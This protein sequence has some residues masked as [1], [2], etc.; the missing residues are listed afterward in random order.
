M[1]RLAD[2]LRGVSAALADT[3]RREE[4]ILI[5]EWLPDLEDEGNPGT[6][7]AKNVIPYIG[8]YRPARAL[9]P[10]TNA[11][12]D[13]VLGG[14]EDTDFEGNVFVYAGTKTKLYRLVDSVFSDVSKSG[15]YSTL[16]PNV[17]KF[18]V[19]D[20]NKWIIGT[21]FDDPV[22]FIEI[23]TTATMFA[24]LITSTRKPTA[25][26]A[27]AVRDFLIL[28]YTN[29]VTDGQRPSRVWNS[30]FNNPR[31]FDPSATTQSTIA[32]LDVGGEITGV[33][34]GAEYGV[35]LQEKNIRRAEITGNPNNPIVYRPVE[36]QRGC[37]IPGSIAPYGRYIYYISEEGFFRFN[38][39]SSEPIG[40]NKVDNT[41][42]RI[43]DIT[44]KKGVSAQI[45]PFNKVVQWLFPA[46]ASNSLPNKIFN[47]RWDTQRW[48]EIDIDLDL[49]FRSR[50]QGTSI[51]GLDALYPS[52]DDVP[53][54]LDDD[55]WK[56]GQVFIGGFDRTH[57]LGSF[58][59]ATLPATFESREMQ[60]NVDGRSTTFYIK[61]LIEFDRNL[62]APQDV[63]QNNSITVG[64]GTRDDLQSMVTYTTPE[65]IVDGKAK[66]RATATYHRCTTE[67]VAGYNWRNITGWVVSASK[68]GKR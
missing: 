1:A 33:V 42:W 56:G 44:N 58:G 34:G 31:D 22:Q 55:I 60:F 11:L 27:A 67:I 61:P 26:Y 19:W 32:D 38:G 13:T 54:S 48:S 57:R 49:I 15:D 23:G 52:I 59:G 51:D 7:I 16:E 8:G 12:D 20:P 68:R 47:Y 62:G 9:N 6:I 66:I 29:D 46:N 10:I 30:A 36:R 45:D 28:G 21:N 43:F 14:V 65:T 63:T 35:V 24:D 64:F 2:K 40:T 5:G 41:F 18:T 50:S 17:W 39:S 37:V 3:A 25:R 4:P 53:G